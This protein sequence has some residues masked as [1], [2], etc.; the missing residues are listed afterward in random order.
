[1]KT[2]DNI[3]GLLGIDAI[4]GANG[5][6]IFEYMLPQI[7]RMVVSEFVG[8]RNSMSSNLSKGS[9]SVM[10]A[11]TDGLS[12]PDRRG[13]V[14]YKF[15]GSGMSGHEAGQS[16]RDFFNNRDGVGPKHSEGFTFVLKVSENG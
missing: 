10:T 7:D 8:T 15:G 12:L 2:G 14:Q 1:M 6:P 16:V 4:L 13:N 5:L 3:T 9:N 11:S